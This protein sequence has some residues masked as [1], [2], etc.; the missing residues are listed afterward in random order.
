MFNTSMYNIDLPIQNTVLKWFLDKILT[1][2]FILGIF[3]LPFILLALGLLYALFVIP[4]GAIV[5]LFGYADRLHRSYILPVRVVIRI[6]CLVLMAIG[7]VIGA[8]LA[9]VVWIVMTAFYY[10]FLCLYIL[11]F[12]FYWCCKSN[13]SRYVVEEYEAGNHI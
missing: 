2:L 10:V 7:I 6:V 11:Y 4:F 8:L 5:Y 13:R 12:M 3:L 9:A 1:L